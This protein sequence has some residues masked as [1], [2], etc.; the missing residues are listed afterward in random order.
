MQIE[1][2]D[3]L[4]FNETIKYNLHCVFWKVIICSSKVLFYSFLPVFSGR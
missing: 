1:G 4:L 3:T 2:D